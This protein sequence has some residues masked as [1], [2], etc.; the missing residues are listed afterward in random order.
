MRKSILGILVIF[1]LFSV[2]IYADIYMVNK[3]HTDGMAVMGQ[4]QPAQ[5]DIQK[6]WITKNKIKSE[7]NDRSSI[8]LLDEN[9]MIILN[10][11][12]KEL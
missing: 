4:E 3:T 10:H 1:L 7:S 5:D 6:V 2:S 9:K 8:I 12:L 11:Q